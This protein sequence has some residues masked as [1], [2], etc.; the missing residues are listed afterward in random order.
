[1]ASVKRIPSRQRNSGFTLVEL[2]VVVAI[3]G[4]LA[5]VAVPQYQIY[6]VRSQITEA[7]SQLGFLKT[8]V[9]EYIQTTG[10]FPSTLTEAGA[11]DGVVH[12]SYIQGLGA[13]ASDPYYGVRIE[14]SGTGVAGVDGNVIYLLSN[15]GSGGGVSK[16]L[17]WQCSITDA[18]G[19]YTPVFGKYVP[20]SCNN[21]PT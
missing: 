17:T 14:V 7:I 12:M 13:V 20:S 10:D 2:M 11:P 21:D 3:I 6:V 9:S 5:G 15:Y 1:M 8:A 4:I 19:A 16:P 18:D